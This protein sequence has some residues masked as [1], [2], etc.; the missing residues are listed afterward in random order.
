M[1]YG[2]KLLSGTPASLMNAYSSLTVLLLI[3]LPANTAGKAMVDALDTVLMHE[4]CTR[5][6]A[7]LASAWFSLGYCIHWGNE[8]VA[9]RSLSSL[10]PL[11]SVTMDMQEEF[12]VDCFFLLLL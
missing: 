3:Q 7:P 6:Q 10:S 8:P 9:G 5:F 12:S 1:V 4:S 11:L 2:L